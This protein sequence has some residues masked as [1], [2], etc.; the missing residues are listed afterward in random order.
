[1]AKTVIMDNG[2]DT[3][4][5]TEAEIQAHRWQVER[6]QLAP[7]H[8]PGPWTIEPG[9]SGDPSVGVAPTPTIVFT[10][11]PNRE[12]RFIDIAVVG[13]TVYDNGEDGNALSWG[14]PEANARL[15]A[16][17]PDMFRFVEAFASV[18]T[19]GEV[20]GHWSDTAAMDRMIQTAREIVAKAEGR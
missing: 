13:S 20:P 18:P 14:D 8:T 4:E 7:R 2:P 6:A 12:D 16:A 10:T 17:A 3:S 5:W 19:E 11:I 15:I 9:D 1:M